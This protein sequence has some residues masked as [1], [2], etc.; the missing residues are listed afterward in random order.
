M[1]FL[2]TDKLVAESTRRSQ[3][4][5]NNDKLSVS[6][7]EYLRVFYIASQTR[8]YF[9][10]KLKFAC[11]YKWFLNAALNT[12]F[13]SLFSWIINEFDNTIYKDFLLALKGMPP[14]IKIPVTTSPNIQSP[15]KDAGSC[16][17]LSSIFSIVSDI[18]A[19]VLHIMS[20]VSYTLL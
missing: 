5:L 13:F 15:S 7:L 4:F 6:L 8:K 16:P 2:N 1:W 10:E 18:F 19:G 11:I 3:V 20:D 9:G 17:L 14:S 12:Y